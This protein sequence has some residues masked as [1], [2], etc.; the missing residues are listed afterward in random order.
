MFIVQFSN[1]PLYMIRWIIMLIKYSFNDDVFSDL[2]TQLYKCICQVK[3]QIVFL[4]NRSLL[5]RIE[6]NSIL[7]NVYI[8]YICVY[9]L[10][11]FGLKFYFIFA[12]TVRE[13]LT[14][15]SECFIRLNNNTL[16][17]RTG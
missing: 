17:S 1:C 2:L 6:S 9:H 12:L 8:A 5:V 11:K 7:Y 4:L 14:K 3:T 15:L 13:V 10:V 16:S